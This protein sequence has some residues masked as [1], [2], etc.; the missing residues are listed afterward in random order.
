MCGEGG[1][2]RRVVEVELLAP[3]MPMMMSKM[4][5]WPAVSVP[6][7]TQRAP[8]PCVQS[9]EARLGDDAAHAREHAALAE[10][11]FTAPFLLI[12]VASSACRPGGLMTHRSTPTPAPVTHWLIWTIKRTQRPTPATR[13]NCRWPGAC[14]ASCPS[15]VVDVL[16]GL[17]LHGELGHGVRDL[18]AEDGHEAGV[19]RVDEAL[20]G[21][22]FGGGAGQRV[23][24]GRVGD[25][26]D[27]ARLV[28]A[29]EDVGDELGHGTGGQVNKLRLSQAF[30]SP[31][32]LRDVDL[33]E[34]D[35]AELEP[36]LDEVALRRRAE[37]VNKPFMPSASMTW[38]K[39]R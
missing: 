20:L 34:L 21:H 30:C 1:G 10:I 5:N 29:E 3:V 39:P 22:H 37:A 32:L 26:P 8:R 38:P 35:A 13:P 15:A 16:G 18:L 14:P 19:E 36:A 27:A 25:Q 23:G 24:V 2:L 6:I 33:E 9:D 12:F 17:A 4:P 7:M 11:K 28:G 31:T